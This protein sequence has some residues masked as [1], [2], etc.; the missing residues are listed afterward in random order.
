MEDG[1]GNPVQYGYVD[2]ARI[3]NRL[4]NAFCNRSISF[5]L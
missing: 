1:P 4:Y 5:S 2:I 3:D